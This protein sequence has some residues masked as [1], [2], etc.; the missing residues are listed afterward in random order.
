MVIELPDHDARK[1]ILAQHLGA[2]FDP[3]HQSDI[4]RRT[5]GFS[6][7]ELAQLARNAKRIARRGRRDVTPEDVHSILPP[8]IVAT[9]EERWLSC[10][11]EAGHA[12]VG[13]ELGFGDVELLVAKSTMAARDGNSGHVLWKR[14]RGI[15]KTKDKYAD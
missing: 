12:V 6:G 4:A 5:S 1:V 10:I 9:D 13:L 14:R 7:A 15:H 8:S 11:H 2:E 3:H